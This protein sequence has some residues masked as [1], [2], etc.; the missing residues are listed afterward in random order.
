MSAIT[1]EV[2]Q[3]KQLELAKMIEQ[4]ASASVPATATRTIEIQEETIEL[5]PGEHYAGTVLDAEG[6]VQHHLVLMAARPDKHLNWRDAM[7]WAE[8]VGGVLP[9]RQEAALFLARFRSKPPAVKQIERLIL[10][11]DDVLVLT[12]EDRITAEQVS[13]IRESLAAA[14]PQRKAIVLSGGMWLSVIQPPDWL[15]RRAEVEQE[16]FD[17]ANGK[18]PMPDAAQLRTWA[19]RLGV[20]SDPDFGRR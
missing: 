1:L 20:P 4:L 15:N 14:L 8:Q 3:A 18:R 13:H 2:V 7:A 9:T 19:L 12:V 11:P 10:G 16:L 17:A 5:Q 6:E